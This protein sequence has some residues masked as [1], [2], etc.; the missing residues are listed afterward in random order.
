MKIRGKLVSIVAS[1]AVVLPVI[2]I[3]QMIRAQ[4]G[5]EEKVS[6]GLHVQVEKHLNSITEDTRMMCAS[7]HDAISIKVE[8][9]LNVARDLLY[10]KG[11]IHFEGQ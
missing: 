5:V 4:N 6:E 1:I 3:F 11:K 7:Q 10:S 8:S 9:D 2:I